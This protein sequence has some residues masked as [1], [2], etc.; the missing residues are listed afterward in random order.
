MKQKKSCG[1]ITFHKSN[2]YGAVLQSYALKT[3]L[4]RY[5]TPFFIKHE[6]ATIAQWHSIRPPMPTN[7]KK[8][9]EFI[10]K[11]LCYFPALKKQQRFNRFRAHYLPER[12]AEQGDF[13]ISGS[14]QVWNYVCNDFNNAYF[15]DFAEKAKRNSYSASFGF[16]EIPNEYIDLYHS[17]LSDFNRISVREKTGSTILKKLINRDVPVTLDPTLLLSKDEWS[18]LIKKRIHKKPYLLVYAFDATKTI[19][20]F[21][22]RLAEE[23]K[24]DVIVLLP[25]KA[26]WQKSAFKN[27]KY[28]GNVS[29][30]DWV[31]YFYYADYVVTNSFHGM[32]FSIN[33]QKTFS[34]ELRPEPSKINSRII[35]VLSLFKLNDRYID[36]P[37]ATKEIDYAP[38]HEILN[39]ERQK[40]MDYLLSIVNDY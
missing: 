15:L 11:T 16:D 32:A 27:A 30:E 36:R 22:N 17:L 29:P 6:N 14:D 18:A 19:A 37:N 9:R 5:C 31:Q 39:S 25:T 1:I 33:F 7:I 24:L 34:A 35:D 4:S 23:R 40:S 3:V 10:I 2:N 38:V 28:L 13:F 26:F 8:M 21:V 12:D 20:N